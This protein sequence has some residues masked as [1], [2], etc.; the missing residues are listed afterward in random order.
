MLI[1]SLG[2]DTKGYPIRDAHSKYVT[3]ENVTY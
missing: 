2:W 1:D 3:K